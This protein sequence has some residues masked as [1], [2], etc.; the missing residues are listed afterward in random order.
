MFNDISGT[1]P[2]K[3]VDNSTSFSVTARLSYCLCRLI[4]SP[5][6]QDPVN[7]SYV[8]K[9]HVTE[10]YVVFSVLTNYF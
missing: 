5:H 3:K 1:D 4:S 10:C 2:A 7:R 8:F 9:F 6:S